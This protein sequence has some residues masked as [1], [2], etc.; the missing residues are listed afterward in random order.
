MTYTFES[1]QFGQ[2]Q[3]LASPV[4]VTINP[5]NIFQ[6]QSQILRQVVSTDPKTSGEHEDMPVVRP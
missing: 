1:P 2:S 6:R 5:K 3:P 4:A